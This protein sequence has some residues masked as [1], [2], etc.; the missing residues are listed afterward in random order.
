MT[1]PQLRSQRRKLGLTQPALGRLL[2]V[3]YVTVGR[4]ERGEQPVPAWLPLALA[5]LAAQS[6]EP[7]PSE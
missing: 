5:G 7:A 3:T 1:G 4:W 6:P 2:G